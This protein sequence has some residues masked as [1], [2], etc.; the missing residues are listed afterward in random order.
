[1]PRSISRKHGP[2]D[3]SAFPKARARRDVLSDWVAGV[4][5]QRAFSII[6]VNGIIPDAA[7]AASPFCSC[8][9]GW[10]AG[11]RPDW[12]ACHRAF[13]FF[14]YFSNRDKCLVALTKLVEVVVGRASVPAPRRPDGR[15][16]LERMPRF[17]VQ[18]PP[19]ANPRVRNG[20]TRLPNSRQRAG[21]PG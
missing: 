1:M 7:T 10:P 8:L 4:W 12:G 3:G 11:G 21:Y 6:I 9:V 18:E 16:N 20:A 17:S 5:A 14:D 15:G 19:S 2:Y 13:G